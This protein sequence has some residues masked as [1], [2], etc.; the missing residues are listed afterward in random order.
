MNNTDISLEIFGVKIA[1]LSYMDLL[2]EIETNIQFKKKLTI[3][4]VTAN[5][6]NLIYND[7]SLRKTFSGI[8]L[9]HPDGIG[10]FFASKILFPGNSFNKRMTGSD[11]YPVLIAEAI[12]NKWKMF[13]W[14]DTKETQ[15]KLSDRLNNQ[16]TF[17]GHPGYDYSDADVIAKIN[18]FK[19][20]ILLVGLGS[21]KQEEWIINN[22]GKIDSNVTIAVGDGLKVFAGTKVRG[23][24][25]A[26]RLG[27]EWVF[28]LLNDP[29]RLWKRYIYGIPLFIL[30]VFS[31]KLRYII[32]SGT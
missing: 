10:V 12:K 28:R 9:V 16:L 18:E 30:R 13:F 29:K 5:S 8:D 6:L 21:P 22:N 15:D 3:T 7:D 23:P 20:D 17:E 1:R 19:P 31:V 25:I 32:R 4:Y 14:G 2:K 27:F 11:F 26:Q 24:K